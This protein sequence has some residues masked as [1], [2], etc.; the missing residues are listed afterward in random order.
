[1]NLGF[2]V[3]VRLV[4]GIGRVGKGWWQVFFVLVGQA[5]VTGP[6]GGLIRL[7]CWLGADGGEIW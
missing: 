4:L 1:M 5:A 7:I 3:L 6:V 2:L